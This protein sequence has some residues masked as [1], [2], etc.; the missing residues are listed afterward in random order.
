[1]KLGI[2]L[3]NYG[4][5]S[6]PATMAACAQRAE[7][8]GID[9]IWV[10]DHIAIPPDNSEGSGGRYVDPLATLAFLAAKTEQIALGTGVLVLPYRTALPT[11]KWVA[12]VQELSRGRLLLGV[13]VG[14]MIEEFRVLGVPFEQRG[15]TSDRIL[16]FIQR[17]F[18]GDEGVENGQPFLFLPRPERPPVYVGGSGDH[19]IRRIARFG[20]GW[21]APRSDPAKLRI[22]IAALQ[23]AMAVAGRDPAEILPLTALPLEDPPAAIDHVQALREVGVTGLIYYGRYTDELA[24]ERQLDQLMTHVRPALVPFSAG[25]SASA[26]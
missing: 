26:S 22:E 2:Y 18:E 16:A 4:P 3:R 11:A 9:Q 5:A 13:G 19:T 20:E 23:E 24:F 17:C 1:M 15:A 25:P 12:S 14:S 8:A 6:E 10:A 7:A 21:I